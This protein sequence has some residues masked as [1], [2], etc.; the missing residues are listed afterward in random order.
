MWDGGWVREA[1]HSLGKCSLVL[2]AREF[3]G[4][5]GTAPPQSTA[6]ILEAEKRRGE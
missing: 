2:E 1:L 3:L 6:G 4:N 5:Q